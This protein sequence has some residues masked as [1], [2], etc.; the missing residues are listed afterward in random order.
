MHARNF[1]INPA[2][3]Q[4]FF[5]TTA[6]RASLPSI[7]GVSPNHAM[8]GVPELRRRMRTR[9]PA[10]TPTG[11][12]W[13]AGT[14]TTPTWAHATK[15]VSSAV[16]PSRAGAAPLA[17]TVGS[18]GATTFPH[19]D[20]AAHGRAGAAP[21]RRACEAL[22]HRAPLGLLRGGGQSD[23]RMPSWEMLHDPGMLVMV[24]Q[25][26]RRREARIQPGAQASERSEVA[27]GDDRIARA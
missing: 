24:A 20:G 23:S 14:R 10:S 21:R 27:L 16:T 26:L 7:A 9:A 2:A 6:D 8:A 11:T 17:R 13:P 5:D 12:P 25:A 1:D 19:A 22:L 3:S 4:S 18:A 15:H